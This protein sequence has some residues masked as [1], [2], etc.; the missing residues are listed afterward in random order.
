MQDAMAL[1]R[2]IS[3]SQAHPEASSWGFH[4]S[5][6]AA[7]HR[8]TGPRL[9]WRLAGRAWNLPGVSSSLGSHP[10]NGK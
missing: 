2:L 6:A 1:D 4:R 10:Q 8:D 3:P 7:G 9:T 5:P